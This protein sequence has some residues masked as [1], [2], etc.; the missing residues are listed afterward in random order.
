M[1]PTDLILAAFEEVE[2]GVGDD[3]AASPLADLQRRSRAPASA[4]A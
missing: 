2:R 1:V 4:G 3:D